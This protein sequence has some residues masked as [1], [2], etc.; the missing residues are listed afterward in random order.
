MR[1]MKY[2][3]TSLRKIA[4]DFQ[5][6]DQMIKMLPVLKK[7]PVI[8][9]SEALSLMETKELFLILREFPLEHQA[10]IFASFPLVKQLSVFQQLSMK[11]FARL[12]EQMPSED[13]AD[14]FQI[15][16]QQEQIDLLPF[17]TKPVRE[18]VLAL[19]S[20][21]EDT[22]GG[23]MSTD[24]ATVSKD[25]TCFEAI[26]KVRLDAPSKKTIYYIYVVNEDQTLLG[27]ITLKDLIIA[28]PHQLVEEEL[29][30]D[31]VFGYV[32]EDNE[33]V[34]AKIDKYELVALPI[35]N[36]KKQLVGIVTHDDALDI[37]QAEH[38]EDMQKFMG[39]MG[40]SEDANYE[41][42]SIFG[43]FKKRVFWL[44]TLAIV[45]LIS[46]LII[47][48]F[49]GALAQMVILALYMPMVADAG[50]NA[51]SQSATVVVRAMALEQITV[52]SWMR[53]L[54]KETRI[55][56]ML[57]LCLG[58]L[59]FGKVVFFSWET[60]SPETTA[61]WIIGGVIAVALFLQ[62]VFSTVIGAALPL[63]VKKMGADPAVVA[64]PAIRTIVNILG[65][66]IYFG[67]AAYI[68]D[69]H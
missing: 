3:P 67:L 51:G 23:I 41:Q 68:F 58:V 52:K 33:L 50:G 5:G 12:F 31:F 40:S 42:T 13:R 36:R 26:H 20:Y 47:H 43:H 55:A 27:F 64:S 14:L 59:A 38:T 65:L 15:L 11:R 39:V 49:E 8:D 4:Q 9:V 22:A 56:L 17:L 25:M 21:P 45:G 35:L 57:A 32:D 34:A 46:G 54:W 37:I 6:L 28:E 53:V 44:V 48:S 16:T 60:E 30:R 10:E 29:H 2:E 19:S 69:L 18:N 7:M 1:T 66:L 62:V 61:L 63:L 24:F